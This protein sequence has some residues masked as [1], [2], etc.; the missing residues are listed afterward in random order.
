VEVVGSI[1]ILPT[2]YYR[3]VEQLVARRAHN[4]EVV[5]SN[6]SPATM[7]TKA[8]RVYLEAFF[9]CILI[10]LLPEVRIFSLCDLITDLL[11]LLG[12]TSIEFKKNLPY[13][14]KEVLPKKSL[15]PS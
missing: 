13:N 15:L 1:P 2:I 12:S 4:P 11:D 3:G 8:F 6:P 9:I 5:G 14:S 7:R 10:N